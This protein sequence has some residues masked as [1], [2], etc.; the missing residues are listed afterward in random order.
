[1]MAVGML[2]LETAWIID[3]LSGGRL[4]SIAAYMFERSTPLWLRALSGFHLL[5]PPLMIF[6]LMQLGYDRRALLAQIFLAW[7]VLAASYL[8]TS[9]EKNINWVFGPGSTPQQF[10]PPLL[11]LVLLMLGIPLFVYA[12]THLLIARVFDPAS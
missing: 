7:V 3:F 5:V 9:P 4:L 8:F 11:Y 2:A 1:M 6:L 12:P 10:M